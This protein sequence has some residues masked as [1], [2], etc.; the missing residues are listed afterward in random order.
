VSKAFC[1]AIVVLLG[2]SLLCGAALA[3]GRA[4]AKSPSVTII[5]NPSVPSPSMLGTPGLWTATVQ[6]APPSELYDYQFSVALATSL[7]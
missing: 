1:V 3:E 5:L 7:S 6:N 4:A 2:L